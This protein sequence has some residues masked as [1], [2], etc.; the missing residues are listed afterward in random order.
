MQY[1]RETLRKT[2]VAIVGECAL[3]WGAAYFVAIVGECALWLG[4]ACFVAIVGVLFGGVLHIFMYPPPLITL[5]AVF[6]FFECAYPLGCPMVQSIHLS[7]MH[8]C[9]AFTHTIHQYMHEPIQYIHLSSCSQCH[10][11]SMLF[12]RSNEHMYASWF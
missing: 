6:S 12:K 9:N 10:T 4:A 8:P 5:G 11:P 1:V 3:W 7:F 2:P